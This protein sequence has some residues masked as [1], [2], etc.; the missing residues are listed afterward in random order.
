MADDEL[1]PEL[2]VAVM[3]LAR[4]LR[5][6]RNSDLPV[7]QLTALATLDRH[8]PL[9]PGEL[10]EAEHVSPPSMTRVLAALDAR[11]LV[12]REAHP[13]DGRQQVVSITDE[14]RAL[15]VADRARRDA[16]LT[17]RL[18]ELG[19][20]ERDALTAAIPVLQTLAGS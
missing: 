18:R 2:R 10:A 1:G 17:C 13:T 15:L 16:W 4:R 11:S 19:P 12:R 9:T 14:A 8:G 3:R 6:E 5:N 20:A 7:G